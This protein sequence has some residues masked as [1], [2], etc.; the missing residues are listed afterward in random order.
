MQRIY[1]RYP[2]IYM[3]SDCGESSGGAPFSLA[4]SLFVLDIGVVA[5]R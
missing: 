1:V 2:V 3:A 5:G 4:V